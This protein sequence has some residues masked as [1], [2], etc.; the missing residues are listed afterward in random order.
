ML[1]DLGLALTRLGERESGTARLE[2]AAAAHREALK[3]YTR[4]RMPLDWAGTQ[5][6]LGTALWRLGERGI[7]GRLEQPCI[8]RDPADYR[9]VRLLALLTATSNFLINEPPDVFDW[10]ILESSD[11]LRIDSPFELLLNFLL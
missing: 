3:E 6:N 10:E 8:I 9:Y 4:E 11:L 2:E 1:N 5:N 7:W